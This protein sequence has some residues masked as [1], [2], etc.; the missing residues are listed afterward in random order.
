MARAKRQLTPFD[1]LMRTCFAEDRPSQFIELPTHNAPA[2]LASSYN[3]TGRARIGDGFV[4]AAGL[5][6][7]G[8][9]AFTSNGNLYGYYKNEPFGINGSGELFNV[10]HYFGLPFTAL[11][12]V[13]LNKPSASGIADEVEERWDKLVETL[14]TE[15]FY[16]PLKD[17][18]SVGAAFAGTGVQE[19]LM[20]LCDSLYFYCKTEYASESLTAGHSIDKNLERPIPLI[21][22]APT[23]P[24]QTTHLPTLQTLKQALEWGMNTLLIGPTATFKTTTAKRA[25]LELRMKFVDVKGMPSS[26]ESV[27]YGSDRTS[28]TSS[29]GFA[30]VDGPITAAFRMARR[31]RVMLLIDEMLRFEKLYLDTLI[32]VMDTYSADEVRSLG[33]EPVTEDFHY[34]LLLANNERIFCPKDNLV[35]IATTNVETGLDSTVFSDALRRRF[36]WIH[37]LDYPDRNI[38]EP[39]YKDVFDNPNAISFALDIEAFTRSNTTVAGGL[40]ERPANPSVMMTL[41]KT[42]KRFVEA[43]EKLPDAL[44]KAAELTVVTYCVGFD[45]VGNPD[46]DALELLRNEVRNL[47]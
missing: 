7:L 5:A 22:S 24:A 40:L 32:G 18:F 46:K 16:Y 17:P 23:R 37:Q 11:I 34:Q 4:E 47:V 38:L 19:C 44:S 3:T 35:F 31:E 33:G 15:N 21:N 1:T 13:L 9:S 26:D 42:A 45:S 41:L 2:H 6:L 12:Q 10:P 36:N 43:G 30:F 20:A 8:H 27:L 14:A 25:A 28:A 39:M 29:T